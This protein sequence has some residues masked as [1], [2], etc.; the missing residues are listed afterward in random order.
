MSREEIY[1]IKKR[2][3][4]LKADQ[5]ERLRMTVEGLRDY[6]LIAFKIY[7]LLIQLEGL[8]KK[9]ISER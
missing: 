4:T 2:I 7:D 5:A 1:E 6:Y 9:V 3:A 8:K